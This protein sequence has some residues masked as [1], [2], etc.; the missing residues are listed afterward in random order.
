MSKGGI[1]IDE[2]E[3]LGRIEGD[4]DIL[5]ELWEVFIE[6]A[7]IQVRELKAAIRGNDASVVEREAHS[8]KSAGAS[9]GAVAFRDTAF[10]VELAA[11]SKDIEKV[12]SLSLRLEEDLTKVVEALHE[13]LSGIA[14]KGKEFSDGGHHEN[15]C[16]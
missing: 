11:R 5:Y 6:N 9:V 16:R 4:E 10:Q 3:A 13:H 12:R 1:I 2:K 14:K 7:P 8:L 15:T